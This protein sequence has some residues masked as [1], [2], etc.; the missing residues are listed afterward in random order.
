MQDIFDS[1]IALLE[2]DSVSTS[3]A[4]TSPNRTVAPG[5]DLTWSFLGSKGSGAWVGL[6]GAGRDSR[7][8]GL[9]GLRGRLAGC[10]AAGSAPTAVLPARLAS[11][12]CPWCRLPG[13]RQPVQCGRHRERGAEQP[14]V[15]DGQR[16]CG[17]AAMMGAAC[18]RGRRACW[19][20]QLVTR[21]RSRQLPKPLFCCRRRAGAGAGAHQ[22]GGRNFRR[23]GGLA[24]ERCCLV[25]AAC[26]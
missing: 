7:W 24:V 3:V 20:Q 22:S 13:P 12:L 25:G 15:H 16:H 21:Q 14:A 26:S 2:P 10:S 8:G 19:S 5:G 18:E 6:G 17:C 4:A 1:Q 23:A 11:L 9:G